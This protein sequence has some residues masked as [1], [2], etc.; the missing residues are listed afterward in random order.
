MTASYEKRMDWFNQ[1]RFGIFVHWGLYSILGRGEW[2]MHFEHI[3]VEEYAKLAW[4][5]NPEKLDIGEWVKLAKEAG[6]KYMVLTTR[7]HDGFCL[8]DSGTTGFT[9]VKTAAKRDF[10]KEYVRACRKYGM[11]IGLYY[12]LLD[13]R[14]PG[15]HLGPRRS[16][17]SFLA[18]IRQAHDQVRE[19]MTCYGK[20]DILWYDGGW[21][22]DVT[23]NRKNPRVHDHSLFA[24]PW[25]A[26]ELNA[27]VR[28]LQPDIIINNRAG[29]DED[30]DTPEQHV[31]AS[32]P[33]RSWEACMTIGDDIGW[34][35]VKHN[36]IFKPTA[37]LIQHLVTAAAGGGNYLLNIGPK[38]DGTV[39]KEYVDRLHEMGRWMK[40]NGESIYGSERAPLDFTGL[41]NRAGMLGTSTTKGNNAYIHIFRWPGREAVIPGIR[42]RVLS[43][44]MLHNGRK[45][46]FSQT[47]DG[48]VLLEGLP[49]NPPDRLDT[50]I[51]LKLDGRPR[52]FVYMADTQPGLPL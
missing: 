7:H 48:K 3:P 19:L 32:R 46:S 26:R 29:T 12:S 30:I 1:A 36:S 6:A 16:P 9:S 45:V 15:Y 21:L 17:E 47:R 23:Y 43:A 24:K 50:V 10:V 27:M 28:K 41:K 40:R 39:Q 35:Y 8:W 31:T 4:R 49:E 37:K 42:N 38:P 5:F 25:R 22:P 52:T 20:V 11:R 33:G 34:G 2:A 44:T 51:K 13:W 18:M 14:F